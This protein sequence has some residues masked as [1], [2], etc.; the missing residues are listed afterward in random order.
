MGRH[1]LADLIDDGFTNPDYTEAEIY[2][3]NEM[4]NEMEMFV[5]TRA[6]IVLEEFN[7]E[8]A[9]KEKSL[10]EQD[11]Q[12]NEMDLQK[13]KTKLLD[14]ILIKETILFFSVNDNKHL[15]EYTNHL[16]QE[17][18]WGTE[19]TL[20]ILHRAIQGER[21][22]RNQGGIF[23]T[24]YDTE[25]VLNLHRNGS[26]PFKQLDNPKMILNNQGNVHWTSKIPDS[27][28][29]RKLSA[30]EQ[31]L[32]KMLDEIEGEYDKKKLPVED[33]IN[34]GEWVRLLRNQLI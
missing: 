33:Y 7:R 4:Q 27:V 15:H 11:N 28:F 17:Y 1:A 20:F 16:Q 29:V 6:S 23:D 3:V 22:V 12:L 30:T 21:L 25:I 8:W 26:S 32:H 19:E 24:F 10:K 13:Q 18:K 34:T 9:I 2:R 31:K 5:V 14:N